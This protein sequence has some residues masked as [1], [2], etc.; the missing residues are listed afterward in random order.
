MPR[1]DPPPQQVPTA[2]PTVA[3]T[4]SPTVPA[5]C[6]FFLFKQ[7]GHKRVRP[8]QTFRVV[9]S[10]ANKLQQVLPDM[11]VTFAL[12]GS[13]T[14]VRA[15]A[16]K[17]HYMHQRP[18]VANGRV[19]VKLNQIPGRGLAKVV[20]ELKASTSA[21]GTLSFP[22]RVFVPSQG[23]CA[24]DGTAKVSLFG[25]RIFVETRRVPLYTR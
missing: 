10:F 25:S 23:P 11:D 4:S 22:Y 24:Y 6:N 7:L 1:H 3:P 5:P 19:T 2:T 14:Y 13:V 12:P 21:S 9:L 16:L 18:I 17:K 8:G 20:L 15:Y